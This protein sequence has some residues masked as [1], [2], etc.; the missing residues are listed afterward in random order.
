MAKFF[1]IGKKM[2]IIICLIIALLTIP[3]SQCINYDFA[4]KVV[5][6]GNLLPEETVRKLKVGMSKEDV[7]IL[8][9]TSLISQTFT[10]DRW[11]FA[12]TWR[13]GT[14]PL[15]VKTLTLYFSKERLVQIKTRA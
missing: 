10:D 6:Q 2:R 4:H 5:R 1:K 3:L 11:D 15:L 12:Y 13:R 14:G 9:G 7:S 8:L